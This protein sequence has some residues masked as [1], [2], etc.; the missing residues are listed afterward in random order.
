M[1]TKFDLS[2]THDDLQELAPNRPREVGLT[3]DLTQTERVDH[4]QHGH[5]GS[6]SIDTLCEFARMLHVGEHW[7]HRQ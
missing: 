6:T 1:R 4:I 3:V 2:G 7:T 5:E